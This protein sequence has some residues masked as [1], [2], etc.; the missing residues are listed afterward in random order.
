M[1]VP[2]LGV[3][4]QVDGTQ[5]TGMYSCYKVMLMLS[6]NITLTLVIAQIDLMIVHVITVSALLMIGRLMTQQPI[7][8]ER[9]SDP[10]TP[11]EFSF[12]I[13][14]KFESIDMINRWGA[15]H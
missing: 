2:F 1:G 4:L 10:S 15:Y 14:L 7:S 3:V 8:L 9:E 12:H 11:R 6:F 13:L 5:P